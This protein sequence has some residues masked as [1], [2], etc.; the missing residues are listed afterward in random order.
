MIIPYGALPGFNKDAEA[1]EVAAHYDVSWIAVRKVDGRR[2]SMRV[3]LARH[4]LFWKLHTEHGCSVRRISQLLNCSRRMV[5]EGITLHK[6]RIE[7]FQA[8]SGLKPIGVKP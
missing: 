3:A 8:T 2:A 7:E 6:K 5:H 4:A 1:R